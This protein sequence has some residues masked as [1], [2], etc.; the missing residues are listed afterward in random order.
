M[1]IQVHQSNLF[2]LQV[3][4]A[5]GDPFHVHANYRSNKATWVVTALSLRIGRANYIPR[6][7][8]SNAAGEGHNDVLSE[9]DKLIQPKDDDER[10]NEDETF[11]NGMLDGKGTAD[12]DDANDDGDDED[13]KSSKLKK[14]R[15][16][17]PIKSRWLVPLAKAAL[18]EKPNISNKDLAVILKPYVVDKF[19]THSLLN[20]KY[21]QEAREA[22]SLWRP[23]RECDL[24]A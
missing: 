14:S 22:V 1:R 16:K 20:T 6:K 9:S 8:A 12:N 7:G 23:S 18:A 24:F 17:S 10:P 11:K 21:D 5:G 4:G 15:V 3:Y 13:G 2:Q 19:L